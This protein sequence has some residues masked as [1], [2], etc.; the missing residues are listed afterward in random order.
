L[1]PNQHFCPC[2]HGADTFA[3]EPAT[4]RLSSRNGQLF[5]YDPNG[6]LTSDGSAT[7]TYTARNEMTSVNGT[8][9]SYHYDA[10]EW[11][12]MKVTPTSITIY[13]RG[14]EGQLLTEMTF[15]GTTSPTFRDYIYAGSRLLAVIEQ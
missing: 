11:R 1:N 6:S 10:D 7:Y 4:L 15:S 3:Y 14:P 13:F 2:R 8:S 9:T 12:M 5:G